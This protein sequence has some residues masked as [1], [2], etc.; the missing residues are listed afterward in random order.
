[1]LGVDGEQE[2]PVKTLADTCI[3]MEALLKRE[4]DYEHGELAWLL[5]HLDT[6]IAWGH[7]QRG[8]ILGIPHGRL[9]LP[10]SIANCAVMA[11]YQRLCDRVKKLKGK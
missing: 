2:A 6:L 3:K 7:E 9:D 5:D 4:N 8:E 1:M 11:R 10:S